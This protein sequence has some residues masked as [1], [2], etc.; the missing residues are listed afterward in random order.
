MHWFLY[1]AEALNAKAQKREVPL[2]IV[3]NVRQDLCI[4]NYLYHAYEH[5]A[6]FE[7]SEPQAAG[8]NDLAMI[9]ASVRFTTSNGTVTAFADASFVNVIVAG[10][11]ADIVDPASD[12]TAIFHLTGMVTLIARGSG[13]LSLKLALGRPRYVSH[14][15]HLL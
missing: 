2:Y 1:D 13:N 14:S 12:A 7:R 3:D 9:S 11:D 10:N 5:F 15:L 6:L 8:V 4:H